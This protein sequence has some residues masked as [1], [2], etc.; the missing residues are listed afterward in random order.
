MDAISK[1]TQDSTML[2]IVPV[3]KAIGK[4]NHLTALLHLQ[5][6]EEDLLK[7]RERLRALITLT[8]DYFLKDQIL[9]HLIQSN[10]A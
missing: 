5:E 7:I 4:G 8:A 1:F 10:Q 9:I 6:R 3:V 2:A